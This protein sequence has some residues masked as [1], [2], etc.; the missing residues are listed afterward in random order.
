MQMSEKNLIR[1]EHSTELICEHCGEHFHYD[2]IRHCWKCDSVTCS[3]CSQS[4]N[5]CPEC[6]VHVLPE[7]IEPM[8]VETGT[9]PRDD[10]AW[11]YEFKWDGIRALSYWNGYKLRI[12]SRNLINITFRY[13]E[14]HDLGAFLGKNAIVDGEI[15]A[16]DKDNR[17][18]FSLLQKRMHISVSK[19]RR[20]LPKMRIQY[21]LFDLLYLN[22]RSYL[23]E[24]YYKRREALENLKIDHPCC[25]VP[26]NFRGQGKTFLSIAQNHHLE[27]IICKKYDSF[28]LPGIRGDQWRKVKL[29]KSREFII[30]GF[31]YVQGRSDRIGSLL[32]GAYD[33]DMMLRFVGPAGTGFSAD[34]HDSLLKILAPIEISENPFHEKMDKEVHFTKPRY[35][36]EVQYARWPAGGLIQQCAYKG[37]RMDKTAAEVKL[38]ED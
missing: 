30:G 31:K 15:I 29:I 11:A 2:Q 34:D 6:R 17:P 14:L 5:I 18:N 22:G 9:L 19:S 12:E 38:R 10:A 3:H 16:L 27:G 32:L 25:K 8:L 36:A 7:N 35:V 13:P 4:E 26:P 20:S 37:V 24:P 33:E 23:D 21:Y 1:S 28:Y